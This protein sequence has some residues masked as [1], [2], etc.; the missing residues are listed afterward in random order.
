MVCRALVIATAQ[1][2]VDRGLDTAVP[3][4]IEQNAEEPLMQSIDDVVVTLDLGG[5]MEV[6]GGDDRACFG[7]DPLDHLSHLENGRRELRRQRRRWVSSACDLRDMGGVVARSF[8]VGDDAKTRDD[9]TEVAGDRLLSREQI[10]RLLLDVGVH[11]I[12]GG[13]L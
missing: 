6:A 12:D 11:R 3:G 5:E 9:G 7:D 8:Q 4:V 2:D 13:V 1:D 10:E